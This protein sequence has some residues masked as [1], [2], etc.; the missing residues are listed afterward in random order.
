MAIK[1]DIAVQLIRC[2]SADPGWCSALVP[3]GF[4]MSASFVPLA[5]TTNLPSAAE[6]GFLESAHSVLVVDAGNSRHVLRSDLDLADDAALKQFI[7]GSNDRDCSCHLA[8]S[9]DGVDASRHDDV[10]FR[11]HQVPGE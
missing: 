3:S 11:R 10:R 7:A 9:D 4:G 2:A 8:N 6:A 1:S 5:R